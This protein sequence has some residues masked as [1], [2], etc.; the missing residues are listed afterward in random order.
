MERILSK[1]A[2]APVRTSDTNG[3]HGRPRNGLWGWAC[4][5]K[6]QAANRKH[7]KAVR[8]AKVGRRTANTSPIWLA[9]STSPCMDPGPLLDRA[10]IGLHHPGFAVLFD[11]HDLAVAG[12]FRS[13]RHF[14]RPV[15]RTAVDRRKH[16][17]ARRGRLDA[18]IV[19]HLRGGDLH[20]RPVLSLGTIRRPSL[21][22]RRRGTP[23]PGI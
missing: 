15:V 5:Q 16:G 18:V 17:E 3:I 23:R 19:L 6:P 4:I 13:D 14:D 11:A 10:A 12:Q 9:K 8:Y 20:P 2:N 22:R 21:L 1:L 7:P